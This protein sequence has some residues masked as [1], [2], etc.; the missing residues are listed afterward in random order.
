MSHCGTN[1]TISQLL[2]WDKFHISQEH[3]G[4]VRGVG[5]AR[6]SS[7]GGGGGGSCTAHK[8]AATGALRVR[9]ETAQAE[10]RTRARKH[11]R[12]RRTMTTQRAFSRGALLKKQKKVTDK[13][14][15]F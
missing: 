1:Q 13:F 6:T 4:A 15:I 3:A 12:T 10:G 11:M 5:G 8:Q 9:A 7:R 14:F 2:T